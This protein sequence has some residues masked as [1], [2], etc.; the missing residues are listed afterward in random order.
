[1]KESTIALIAAMPEETR[2][3][4]RRVRAYDRDELAG[5]PL[6]RF[7]IADR[8][9]CLIESGMG[10]TRAAR[11]A[12]ALLG[13]THPVLLI[14]FGFGGAVRPGPEIGDVVV[15]QQLYSCHGQLVTEEAGL[16]LPPGDILA[17]GLE[18]G[19][20]R[21]EYAVLRGTFVTVAGILAKAA[22]SELL[23]AGA[24]HPVLE[25]E[26]A[27]V[28]RSAAQAGVPFVA[29][30]AI[31]DDAG[32]ELGFAITDFTDAEMNVKISRVLATVAKNPRI[33]PQLLRLARNTSVAGRNLAEAVTSAVGI[34][35]DA[36][37]PA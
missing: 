6:Y 3:L 18:Q 36:S 30:R 22:A 7:V 26:T 24:T 17:S 12:T 10:P 35:G 29:L 19:R 32:E 1:M 16:A 28:A 8:Q 23:P 21:E 5:F 25:M 31:S 33:I 37:R 11:A 27:A 9:C 15:A 13:A 14:N 20:S 34:L 2:P 4:L